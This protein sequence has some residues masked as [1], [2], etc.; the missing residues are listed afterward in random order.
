MQE[1]QCPS[2]RRMIPK[3]S[4]SDSSS[5]S[6]VI[7]SKSYSH[8][9]APETRWHQRPHEPRTLF[10]VVIFTFVL[11]KMFGGFAREPTDKRGWRYLFWQCSIYCVICAS[12]T[13][14]SGLGSA[15]VLWVAVDQTCRVQSGKW[16]TWM[17]RMNL[18]IVSSVV[19]GCFL[20][21]ICCWGKIYCW[22]KI[23][24][25]V[26]GTVFWIDLTVES[27]TWGQRWKFLSDK[28]YRGNKVS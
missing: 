6:S 20:K 13:G 9:R 28:C 24:H 11:P 14:L 12:Y 1:P 16:K 27:I 4:H 21:M 18:V 10:T 23:C 25:Y 15:I 19:C 2:P 22:G 26:P 8:L 7:I 5:D 3:F 17:I